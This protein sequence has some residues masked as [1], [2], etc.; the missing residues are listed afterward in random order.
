MFVHLGCH[1]KGVSLGK[2]DV[3]LASAAIVVVAVAAAG[4]TE[5]VGG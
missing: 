5:G 1:L 2:R 3:L 4:K